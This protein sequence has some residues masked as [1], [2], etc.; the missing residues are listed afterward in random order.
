M[1]EGGPEPGPRAAR[2]GQAMTGARPMTVRGEKPTNGSDT[3]YLHIPALDVHA[4][5]S[6]WLPKWVCW[7]HRCTAH[8]SDKQP[9]RAWAVWGA[10]VC[11]SH[12]GAAPQVRRAA[13]RRLA[14]E[15]WA[16]G[17]RR[18]LAKVGTDA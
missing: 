11:V 14:I 5:L 7:S 16:R 15:A 13:Q 1:A 9:C 10:T 3:G 18:L 12:G 8:R 2:L 6:L 17:Y 4:D